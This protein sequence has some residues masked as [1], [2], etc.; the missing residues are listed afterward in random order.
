MDSAVAE[1]AASGKQHQDLRT[2]ALTIS[3]LGI[4]DN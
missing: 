3:D 2:W 4:C 1:P